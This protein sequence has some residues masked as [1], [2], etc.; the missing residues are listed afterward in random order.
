MHEVGEEAEREKK[1]EGGGEE[2][3]SGL[4][5]VGLEEAGL[6]GVELGLI[7]GEHGC[8]AWHGPIVSEGAEPG[9]T[10]ND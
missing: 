7:L 10:L 2:G 5:A 4:G 3:E 8:A 1:D 9:A 6:E